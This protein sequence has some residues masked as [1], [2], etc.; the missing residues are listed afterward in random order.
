MA[1][2]AHWTRTAAR[3]V[4]LGAVLAS[5]LARAD[6]W[7][8]FLKLQ[9]YDGES[10]D[11]DH[12]GWCDVQAFGE[13]ASLPV[14][15]R[16]GAGA[17][18]GRAAFEP[19]SVTK[20]PDRTTPGLYAAIAKGQTIRT[21]MLDLVRVETTAAGRS[22]SFL[23]I[24][25]RNILVSGITGSGSR[26]GVVTEIL[27]LNPNEITMNSVRVLVVSSPAAV[28][29]ATV[30]ATPGVG[31]GAESGAREALASFRPSGLGVDD[32]AREW[33]SR[34]L[35]QNPGA[36]AGDAAADLT[37]VIA[38]RSWEA[39][40]GLTG[41][42]YA[43]L[44]TAGNALV[45]QG[46]N[47]FAGPPGGRP[48]VAKQ[49]VDVSPAAAEIDGGRLRAVLSGW[50]AGRAGDADLASLRA[51]FLDA[52]D[53]VLG[54]FA[55][56]AAPT[57]G[58]VDDSGWQRRQMVGDVPS[59]TR[60]IEVV[61]TLQRYRDI[62]IGGVADELSLTLEESEADAGGAAVRVQV[63]R[64]ADGT[65][66][67]SV[68]F[69]WSAETGPVVVESAVRLDGDWT[70]DSHATVLRDGQRVFEVPIRDDMP[71]RFWRVRP[72]AAAGR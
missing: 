10:K 41:L 55:V 39:T 50:L 52:M 3:W 32:P 4:A 40:E 45:P 1:T 43:A 16:R 30:L 46:E 35:L 20:A 61:I 37:G 18:V 17:S 7:Q 29:L 31:A 14:T 54:T 53:A 60:A 72:A 58:S 57:T 56:G 23:K 8:G 38:P 13:G 68:R 25:L 9:G 67:P 70:P 12:P 27:Q 34:N 65:E 49:R 62:A 64:F 47:L 22:V 44:G 11:R 59:G 48:G 42:R 15:Y 63:S 69:A 5:A 33:L 51:Q 71:A 26:N 28:R 19:L 66:G 21:G 24:E 2:N 36:E 6:A